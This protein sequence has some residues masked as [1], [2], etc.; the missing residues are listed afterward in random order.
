MIGPT[1]ELALPMHFSVE[2]DAIYRPLRA[3]IVTTFNGMKSNP[4][5]GSYATWEIPVLAKYRFAMGF[6]RPFVE[7]GPS[8]RPPA[9]GLSN[10]GV[11]AGAGIEA[12]LR[13]LKIAPSLRYTHWTPD[14]PSGIV[15]N[16]AEILV[17]FAF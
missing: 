1:V 12:H 6:I 5:P 2:A 9:A 13:A 8:F 7:A 10:Y 3:E 11:T 14:N 16:Q 4:Y 15:P 17:G